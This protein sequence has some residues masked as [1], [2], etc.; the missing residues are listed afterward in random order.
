MSHSPARRLSRP[1]Y[2]RPTLEVAAGLLGKC[3]VHHHPA[4]TTAGIIVEAEAYVGETD[5][6]SHAAPGPT[7]RNQPMY[8]EPGRAYVYFNYG[9]HFMMNVVTEE[10][11]HPAAILIRALEPADGLPLMRRRR[12]PRGDGSPVPD[13]DLCKGPGNLTRAMGITLDLNRA[14]LAGPADRPGS[15]H[16]RP[17]NSRAEPRRRWSSATGS[18]WIEDR[19]IVIGE[20]A[21]TPRIGIRVGTDRPWRCLV[22]GHPSVSATPGRH[23]APR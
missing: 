20:I 8:G 17:I 13:P 1:F 18:L 9:V 2:D 21:W 15:R 10:T 16:G 12:G 19:G 7:P 5:P 4:G 6:A 14:D 22:P 11:G 23:S 3:L